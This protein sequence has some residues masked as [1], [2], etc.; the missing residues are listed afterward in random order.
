MYRINKV[1]NHNAVVAVDEEGTNEYLLIG[2]GIGFGK[3][4]S[5]RVETGPE[6]NI[7]SLKPAS[8]RGDAREIVRHVNPECLELAGEILDEAQKHVGK[9]DR[10][11]IFPLADHLEYAIRRTKKG[12]SISN[13]LTPD[14]QTIFYVEYKVAMCAYPL[15]R[16]RFDLEISEDEIGFIALHIHSAIMDEKVSDALQTAEI[17]RECVEKIEE[18]TG[19]RVEIMSLGYNRMMNHIRYMVKRI[20]TGEKLKM[21]LNDYM[22]LHYPE[23]FEIAGQV[24]EDMSRK[25]KCSLPDAESGYLAMHIQRVTGPD[26]EGDG[27]T[28]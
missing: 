27:M 9:L 3:K 5:E 6:V 7:Y 28:E 8:E 17:V 20:H 26:D 24:C 23:A 19:T 2:R 13:P 11:A 1:L 15:I 16:K 4:I 25:L 12:E 18:L 21:N 10:E 22:K 14:I